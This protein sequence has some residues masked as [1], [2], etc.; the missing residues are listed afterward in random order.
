M[1]FE[2]FSFSCGLCKVW[3]GETLSRRKA[4][5]Q[6]LMRNNGAKSTLC[7]QFSWNIC[8]C[9][10]QPRC[11]IPRPTPRTVQFWE[12]KNVKF[13]SEMSHLVLVN[14]NKYITMENIKN[15]FN[16]KTQW[17]WIAIIVSEGVLLSYY[18]MGY[19]TTC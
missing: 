2:V 5:K 16:N 18:N 19:K 1:P 17:G 15:Y 11:S 8:F 9:Q 6:S 12:Q 13:L 14:N 7:S 4:G 3:V 10:D